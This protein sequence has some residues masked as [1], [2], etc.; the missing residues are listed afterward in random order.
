MGVDVY[1]P[2][3]RLRW[4]RAAIAIAFLSGIALS[5]RLWLSHDREYPLVAVADFLPRLGTPLE[6]VLLAGLVA[7][8]VAVAVLPRSRAPLVLALGIALGL[9]LFDQ[10]RWQPWVYQYVLMLAALTMTPRQAGER[11]K[12]A[13]VAL[14]VCAFIVIAIYFWSGLSKI[15]AAFRLDTFP[16]LLEPLVGDLPPFLAPLAYAVPVVEVS[17]GLGLVWRRTRPY[18]VV[19]AILM[20][21]FILLS[22]GPL[23]RNW[24]TVVWPW[25]VAMV[26][27]VV[28]L[29]WRLDATPNRRLLRGLR[30]SPRTTQAFAC[31]IAGLVGVAPLLN[32]F[33]R[34]DSYLSAELYS[35]S[36]ID[37]VVLP[38]R[39]LIN[40]LPQSARRL[41]VASDAGPALF[42]FDWAIEDLN[43]PAY[44]AQ[45]VLKRVG[46]SM[47]SW[48]DTPDA[49]RLA[50]RERPDV[51][52]GQ[53]TVTFYGCGDLPRGKNGIP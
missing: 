40:Q 4:V 48:S 19:G 12:T 47:C 18:A 10:N 41:V 29:F 20:H 37:G 2:E 8:L 5:P 30:C 6:A 1:R 50:I 9:A 33:G 43:V 26:A 15:G 27:F 21:S 45:R 11:S 7:S 42:L 31:V 53:R 13:R 35:G 38:S 16:W 22:I 23:G 52:S 49:L 17:I 24:N 39:A 14:G 25:N 46:G 51:L 32:L 28:L 3:I 34:W 44:P 36:T